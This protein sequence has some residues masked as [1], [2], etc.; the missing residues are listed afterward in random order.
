M[1]VHHIGENG[2]SQNYSEVLPFGASDPHPITITIDSNGVVVNS[3]G[4]NANN[5]CE[6]LIQEYQRRY[7]L[8]QDSLSHHDRRNSVTPEQRGQYE[9]LNS[10][11]RTIDDYSRGNRTHISPENLRKVEV[12]LIPDRALAQRIQGSQPSDLGS[13]TANSPQANAIPSEEY[14]RQQ[15]QLA[16][17]AGDRAQDSTRSMSDRNQSWQSARVAFERAS[18]SWLAMRQQNPSNPALTTL[19][20]EYR[21]AYISVFSQPSEQGAAQ[22]TVPN[23]RPENVRSIQE[24][25]THARQALSN[26][27]YAFSHGRNEEAASALNIAAQ[28]YRTIEHSAS[29]EQLRGLYHSYEEARNLIASSL[30][31]ETEIATLSAPSYATQVE[32]LDDFQI[33][34]GTAQTYLNA[35]NLDAARA[36]LAL[37]QRDLESLRST[38]LDTSEIESRQRTVNTLIARHYPVARPEAQ[39]ESAV[40]QAEQAP[41]IDFSDDPTVEGS[42]AYRAAQR[43]APRSAREVSPQRSAHPPAAETIATPI[44]PEHVTDIVGK[45]ET[46][47]NGILAERD[48]LSRPAQLA[49]LQAAKTLLQEYGAVLGDVASNMLPRIDRDIQA[50]SGVEVDTNLQ[51]RLEAEGR[52]TLVSQG[53]AA[54]QRSQPSTPTTAAPTPAAPSPTAAQPAASANSGQGISPM[55]ARPM[56]AVEEASLRDLFNPAAYRREVAPPV[57]TNTANRP[58]PAVTPV[59]PQPATPAARLAAVTIPAAAVVTNPPNPQPAGVV[60]TAPQGPAP[61]TASVVAAAVPVP[62][63]APPAASARP[64]TPVAQRTVTEREARA[65]RVEAERAMAEASRLTANMRRNNDGVSG[66]TAEAGA[67]RRTLAQGGGVAAPVGDIATRAPTG[68]A[69]VRNAPD[70]GAPQVGGLALGTQRVVESGGVGTG[71]AGGGVVNTG[72]QRTSH[73]PYEINLAQ[74]PVLTVSGAAAQRPDFRALNA[75]IQQF[76]GENNGIGLQSVRI[77][78]FYEPGTT[79]QVRLFIIQPTSI[80]QTVGNRSVNRQ[81]NG[82]ET[83]I[84]ALNALLSSPE[85]LRLI[86]ERSTETGETGEGHD[87]SV[88]RN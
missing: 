26:A 41:D 25:I 64:V 51:Q 77:G 62:P 34:L 42:R 40:A 31:P 10:L 19:D 30:A 43:P 49:H 55:P 16:Q 74:T 65:A 85:I 54:N 6:A 87:F 24:T 50:L 11:L 67:A 2:N 71:G 57:Q 28:D 44:V 33:H 47:I 20:D 17:Q 22:A 58:T 88:N 15:L 84:Q 66:L 63:P 35:G 5:V 46:V 13:L 52:R 45:I 56:T 8:L 80:S 38:G 78:V 39:A 73:N 27:R 37:A 4:A 72:P 60:P 69:V 81:A 9:E 12:T 21:Q 82:R 59:A 18:A 1:S 7:E 3:R 53:V 86:P 32:A 61:T 70:S 36:P 48:G 29:R 23:E 76:M 83:Q 14:F 79:N 68:T 75:R